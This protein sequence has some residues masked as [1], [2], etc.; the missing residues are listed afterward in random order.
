V[1]RDRAADDVPQALVVCHGSAESV[2]CGDREGIVVPECVTTE[3]E[4]L[5]CEFFEALD[6][7]VG[8][9]VHFR[10]A[11]ELASGSAN[12]GQCWARTSVADEVFAH[13]IAVFAACVMWTYATVLALVVIEDASVR[14]LVIV[15]R[16]VPPTL[17]ICL[18]TRKTRRF[19]G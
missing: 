7:F 10:V 4:L 15:R 17:K 9:F 13:I 18:D 6:V 2:V 19:I 14:K 5:V 11:Q 8:D 16:A 3:L 12:F 1:L